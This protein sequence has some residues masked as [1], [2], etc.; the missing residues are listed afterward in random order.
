MEGTKGF[1][2]PEVMAILVIVGILLG[3]GLHSY[4][5]Y[6]ENARVTRARHQPSPF[7]RRARVFTPCAVCIRPRR[8]S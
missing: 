5:G 4:A 1:T 2:L 3:L 8:P 6:L 7:S